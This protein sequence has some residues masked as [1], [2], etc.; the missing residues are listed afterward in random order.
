MSYIIIPMSFQ[1]IY[2][3]N[4]ARCHSLIDSSRGIFRFFRCYAMYIGD[5]FIPAGT[6]A[7]NATLGPLVG[8]YRN[9]YFDFRVCQFYEKLLI[10][11]Q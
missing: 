9:E 6:V 8:I 7:N 4:Y 1:T 10:I 5:T 3:I 2:S 11:M